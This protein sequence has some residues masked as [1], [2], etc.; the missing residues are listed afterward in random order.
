MGGSKVRMPE[1]TSRAGA[2]G[3]QLQSLREQRALQQE[4]LRTSDLLAPAMYRAAGLK[5]TCPRAE[6]PASKRSPTRIEPPELILRH[7]LLERSRKALR[8]ELGFDPAWRGGLLNSNAP[9]QY[10]SAAARPWLRPSSAELEALATQG[11]RAEELRYGARTGQLTLAEQL[12]L[13]REQASEARQQRQFSQLGGAL[14]VSQ[15]RG[16]GTSN[17]L[18]GIQSALGLGLQGRGQQAQMAQFQASQPGFLDFLGQ[19]L[20]TGVGGASAG[21]GAAFGKKIF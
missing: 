19:L 14:G 8:G 16:A 2:P 12:G 3:H 7:K 15:Q 20:L 13:Q 21:A 1:P 6:S 5:P 4:N 10:P 11:Q 17:Y 9:S 18:Q